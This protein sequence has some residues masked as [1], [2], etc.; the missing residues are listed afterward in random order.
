MIIMN[1]C[2]FSALRIYNWTARSQNKKEAFFFKNLRIIRVLWKNIDIKKQSK[3]SQMVLS[4]IY[5]GLRV[6]L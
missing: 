5:C 6:H 1:I 3:K 4:G 2:E